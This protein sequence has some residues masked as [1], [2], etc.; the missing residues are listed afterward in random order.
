LAAIRIHLERQV[1]LDLTVCAELP[2]GR[3]EWWHV[4][5]VAEHNTGGQPVYLSGNVRD[6]TSQHRCDPAGE[7]L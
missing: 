5:G 3:T 4:Q 7:A 6:V 1:P 2:E